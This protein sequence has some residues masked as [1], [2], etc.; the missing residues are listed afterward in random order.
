MRLVMYPYTAINL[1]E[2]SSNNIKDFLSLVDIY[3]LSHMMMFTNTEKSSYLKLAKMPK[4]PTITFKIKDYCLSSDIFKE[5]GN[6]KRP[7]TK[8]FD[9]VPLIIMNGFNSV[10][11]PTEYDTA[12]KTTSMMFQSFFPPLNLTE[13]QIKKCKRVVLVTL[14]M[15]KDNEPELLFRHYD[16]EIEKHSSKKTISNLINS[17]NVNRD[18]S[19]FSNIAD[20]VLKQSGF[21]S[22]SEN[23]DPNLGE[24]D[25]INEK[26]AKEEKSKIK[27]REI[28]PRLNLSIHK[29][30]EG[31]L[32][33]N[34]IFHS[35]IKK[36]KKEIYE[37]M[38]ELKEKRKEKKMRREEQEK[39]I[40]EKE[41]KK[42][43]E[44]AENEDEGDNE[45]EE[46][47]KF[48]N[49]K[50]QREEKNKYDKNPSRSKEEKNTFKGKVQKNK[51]MKNTKK[52]INPA[53]EMVMTKRSL[54][55]FKN[56]K[57]YKK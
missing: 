41:M 4:G 7:L 6:N 19:N 35:L 26:N 45:G 20:Y 56:L 48:L 12:M 13:I 40:K 10:D 44:K 2:S 57:K 54:K 34:V 33:G 55:Q 3:G 46:E 14:N 27:L 23:E 43:K 5:S 38:Q 49:K 1:R 9:H 42:E 21:T 28:G 29:I 22:Q 52:K 25:I 18:F 39:N 53:K 36:S 16:I 31:F 50:H 37:I 8:N 15:S 47:P 51:F 11:I 30:E 32:K 24:C 17:I